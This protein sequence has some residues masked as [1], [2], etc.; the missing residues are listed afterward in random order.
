MK[1][2]CG[3]LA[4]V[5]VIFIISYLINRTPLITVTESEDFVQCSDTFRENLVTKMN[6]EEVTITVAGVVLDEFD[7]EFYVSEEMK[8]MVEG[9]FLKRLL[10]C[11]VLEYKDGTLLL[12]KGENTISM[13]IG[14][15]EA[16]VNDYD[17]IDLGSAIVKDGDKIFIPMDAIDEYVD[18]RV[19]Y[20]YESDWID[21]AKDG[22]ESPLPVAYD[23]RDYDRVSPVR[24]QGR[25]GTCWAFASLGA[26]ETTM[27]PMKKLIFSTDHMTLCNSY[28]LD[29]NRGGEHTMSIAYLAAWQGPVYEIDDP[30]GDGASNPELKAVMHLEEAL[31]INDRDF[32]IIK[33]AIFRYG[34]IET[35][36]YSQME[37]VDSVSQYYSEDNCAYYYNGEEAPNHDVVVVGWD[38]NYPKEN[39]THQPEGDGAFICKNSWGEEFGEDGYFYVSYYDANICNKAVVYTRVGAS[40][41]YDKIYQSDLLGWI[42]HLGFGKEDAYFANVYRA[43]ANEELAAVS[44]YATDKDTEF[45]VYIVQ[46]FAGTEDFQRREFLV[47]GNTKY[48][49]YYTVPLPEP[50]RLDDNAKY[51]VVVKIRTPGAIHPIAIEYDVDDRTENFDI[52]DGEGYISLYGELWH[53]AEQTQECN[54]CLKAFT[55]YVDEDAPEEK[56]DTPGSSSEVSTE[57][58]QGTTENGDTTDAGV[59]PEISTGDGAEE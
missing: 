18:Y 30:Y 32:E 3:I 1:R 7:Y 31:V 10:S 59:E 58:T 5:V 52:T 57:T 21:I 45:E 15:K 33:S 48:A 16:I 36:L 49:G 43:G 34:A 46:N 2:I 29:L 22:E 8:L 13:S 20:Y 55:N 42:G 56:D 9:E 17:I 12:M 38:D 25:Y 24:D 28:N 11:S 4:T 6:M 41:N 39:F 27:L 14:S 37:Y 44:F 23:M 50:V 19:E 47:A 26:L 54:V 35:S 53:S 51:A 40:D